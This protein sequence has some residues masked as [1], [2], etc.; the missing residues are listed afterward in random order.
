AHK[1]RRGHVAV[2]SGGVTSSGAARLAA[3][4]AA[5]AGAGAVTVLS[6]PAALLPNAAHLTAT[7]LRRVEDAAAARTF[8]GERKVASVVCGPGFGTGDWHGSMV[9]SLLRVNETALVLDADAIALLARDPGLLQD[10]PTEAAPSIVLTPH[11]GEFGRLFP[12]IAA[13]TALSKVDRARLAAER[14]Q[15]VVILKGPDTVVAASDGRAAINSNGT[16]WLATAGSGDVLAGIVAALIAGGMPPF[17]AACAAVWVHAEAG[18]EEGFG[19]T[20]EDLPQAARRV[21]ARLISR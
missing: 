10:R 5:R 1:Y 12:D 13:D 7:M 20:A 8:I 11:E 9:A 18:R 16:V 19:L 6:P 21:L 17:G 4:A 14:A 3:E 15:A 2:L